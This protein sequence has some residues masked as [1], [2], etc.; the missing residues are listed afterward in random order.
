MVLCLFSSVE[1]GSSTRSRWYLKLLLAVETS[2]IPYIA[3]ILLSVFVDPQASSFG[4][5]QF[6]SDEVVGMATSTEEF[7]HS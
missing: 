1:K 2:Q 4:A 5:A 3:C 7:W 6:V